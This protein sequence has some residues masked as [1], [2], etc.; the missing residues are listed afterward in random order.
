[1]RILETK[2]YTISEHPKKELCFDYIRE[3]WH[4]LNQNSVNEFMDSLKALQQKI[5]GDLDYS[6]GQFASRGE[7]ISLKNYDKE[8]LK[9]I[10]PDSYSLTGVFWD[11]YV[12][13]ALQKGNIFN[14]INSLHKDSE[15][16]YSDQGLEELCEANDYEFTEKGSLIK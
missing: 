3:N 4:D 15:Y 16:V 1:M 14:S 8:I 13:T 10:D 9:E 6:I 5:G 11:Y 7:F 2:V 12:V